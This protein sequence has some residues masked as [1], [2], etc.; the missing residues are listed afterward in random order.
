MRGWNHNRE[1]SLA[2]KIDLFL[3]VMQGKIIKKREENVYINLDNRRYIRR[4]I[5]EF[6]HVD[7]KMLQAILL[8]PV[9]DQTRPLSNSVDAAQVGRRVQS[10]IDRP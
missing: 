1:H 4:S 6:G 5:L 10:G 8:C 7:I 2:I 9:Q 3:L